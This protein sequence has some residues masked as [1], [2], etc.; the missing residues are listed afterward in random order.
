[1]VIPESGSLPMGRARLE[2]PRPA[3]GPLPA[4]ESIA[5]G[6]GCRKK[7]DRRNLLQSELA[8]ASDVGTLSET[9][10]LTALGGCFAERRAKSDRG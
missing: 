10:G 2:E 8:G 5:R 9:G 7:I 6:R 4:D 1:M 3:D